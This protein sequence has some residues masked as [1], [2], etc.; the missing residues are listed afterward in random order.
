MN[1]SLM[2]KGMDHIDR[3]RRWTARVGGQSFNRDPGPRSDIVH[4]D[5]LGVS[6][7]PGRTIGHHRASASLI[8]NRCGDVQVGLLLGP[9]R[10][11]RCGAGV[12]D[13]ARKD[14]ENLELS[15]PS[16]VSHQ[17]PVKI[18]RY[19]RYGRLQVAQC[20]DRHAGWCVS[21]EGEGRGLPEQQVNAH[22]RRRGPLARMDSGTRPSRTAPK[23]GRLAG[24]RLADRAQRVTIANA[25][26]LDDSELASLGRATGVARRRRRQASTASAAGSINATCEGAGVVFFQ[27]ECLFSG[28]ESREVN[29]ADGSAAT[30]RNFRV[31]PFSRDLVPVVG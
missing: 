10:C 4:Y 3:A 20:R 18:G 28:D 7:D 23:Q 25:R 13:Q 24:P 31:Q 27:S 2:R 15:G 12:M 5:N 30:V 29:D 16:H 8:K 14:Q 21:R 6:M 17:S 19:R 9:A 11:D 26:A 1:D 22:G